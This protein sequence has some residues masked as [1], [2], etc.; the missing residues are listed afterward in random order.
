MSALNP[1]T[2]LTQI[3][4]P[5]AGNAFSSYYT[6]DSQ[7]YNIEQVHNYQTLW[8][9]G[10]RG[11]EFKTAQGYTPAN[12]GT[13]NVDTVADEYF[14]TNGQ[15]MTG[16]PT[17]DKAFTYLAQQLLN[18]EYENEFLVIIATY[19][20]YTGCGAYDPQDYVNDLEKYFRSKMG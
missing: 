6:G 12:D 17:F 2:Y 10:V 15:E 16:G 18:P 9:M 5:V 7:Q 20:S 14:V 19:Q 13:T 3:S 4:V 1:N 8:N 11:F